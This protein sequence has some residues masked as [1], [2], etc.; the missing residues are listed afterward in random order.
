MSTDR[1]TEIA[2]V[3]AQLAAL[4]AEQTHKEP[5]EPKQQKRTMPERILLTVEEA[6][7]RLCIGRTSMYRLVSTGQIESVRI[8]R[9]RRIPTSAIDDYA[10]H[11]VATKQH[12]A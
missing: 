10:A 2:T 12:A 3:L 11:L 5:E 4:L 7:E 8:G 6:A 1:T 9:L